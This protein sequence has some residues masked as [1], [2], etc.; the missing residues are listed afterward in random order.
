MDI[1][2]VEIADYLPFRYRKTMLDKRMSEEE[3]DNLQ[4]RLTNKNIITYLRLISIT[5][6]IDIISY[7]EMGQKF[8]LKL[9]DNII[10]KDPFLEKLYNLGYNIGLNC[11]VANKKIVK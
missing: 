4:T 11:K 7:P 9:S 8:I 2:Q 6:G 10:I 3:A 5:E 1:S